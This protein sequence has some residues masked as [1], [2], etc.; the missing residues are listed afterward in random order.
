MHCGRGSFRRPTIRAAIGQGSF[1]IPTE[2]CTAVGGSFIIPT[3]KAAA[4]G[5]GGGEGKGRTNDQSER[6]GGLG[7]IKPRDLPRAA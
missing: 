2:R 1:I 6:V 4:E 5:K 3:L 7:D